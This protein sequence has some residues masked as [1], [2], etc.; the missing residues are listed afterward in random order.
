M[1]VELLTL[2]T[3]SAAALTIGLASPA[4]G[5]AFQTDTHAGLHHWAKQVTVHP[6]TLVR[7]DDDDGDGDGDGGGDDSG[8]DV[9]QHRGGFRHR[10]H[11]GIAPFAFGDEGCDGE[12]CGDGDHGG[13]EESEENCCAGGGQKEKEKEV[14]KKVKGRV[15]RMGQVG[16]VPRGGVPTGFGGS[17]EM[18]LPMGVAGLSLILGGTGL[19]ARRRIRTGARP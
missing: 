6:G 17:R 2:T 19:L 10:H 7:G 15:V 16:A 5:A 4:L 12:S 11:H 9:E 8:G 18:S 13:G 3:A 14:E 1:R